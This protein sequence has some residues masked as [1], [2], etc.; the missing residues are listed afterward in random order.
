MDLRMTQLLAVLIFC[1]QVT[2]G[3]E[4]HFTVKEGMP[5]EIKCQPPGSISLSTI[6][7]RALDNA[8]MEF[9]AAFDL[10]RNAKTT[11]WR[12]TSE[13]DHSNIKKDILILKSFNKKKDSGQ[14]SCAIYKGPALIFGKVTRLV[15]ETIATPQPTV[16]AATTQTACTTAAECVCDTK[17][18]AGKPA[19]GLSLDCAPLILGPLAGSCGLLLLLLIITSLYCNKIRTRRCPHHHKRKPRTMPGGTK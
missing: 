10:N 4:E 16:A 8:G 15:G 18:F 5:V 3:A 6:W 19:M 17:G 1:Q 11:D 13:F 14:Y 2:W 7:F 12:P 9:I